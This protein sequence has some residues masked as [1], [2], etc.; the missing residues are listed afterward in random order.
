MVFMQV[1]VSYV[2]IGCLCALRQ[3][4]DNWANFKEYGLPQPAGLIRADAHRPPFRDDLH[5]ASPSHIIPQPL[6]HT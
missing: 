6:E 1:A 2:N 3:V 4:A 5:E